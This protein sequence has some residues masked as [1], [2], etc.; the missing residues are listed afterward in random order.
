[1]QISL[2]YAYFCNFNNIRF[3]FSMQINFFKLLSNKILLLDITHLFGA[4]SINQS[5]WR[6]MAENTFLSECRTFFSQFASSK[7]LSLYSFNKYDTHML[8]NRSIQ[9]K[10]CT[11]VGALI[12]NMNP[13][14]ICRY[15]QMSIKK[16]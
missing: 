8:K 14:S 16:P 5:Y 13:R 15:C 2:F 6:M 11:F 3:I 12:R 1:M 7:L 4:A 9:I 10:W